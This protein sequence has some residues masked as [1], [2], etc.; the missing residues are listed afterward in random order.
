MG[1]SINNSV[2]SGIIM[3]KHVIK[4]SAPVKIGPP[5]LHSLRQGVPIFYSGP[6]FPLIS[7]PFKDVDPI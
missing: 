1:S 7:F 3:E 5:V 4:V 2:T 6:P